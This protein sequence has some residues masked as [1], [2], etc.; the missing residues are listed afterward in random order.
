MIV[1]INQHLIRYK[2]YEV[3]FLSVIQNSYILLN[4]SDYILLSYI[5]LV[6]S[7]YGMAFDG[8]NSWNFG[9]G[10][11]ENVVTFSAHHLMIARKNF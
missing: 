8:A 7:G 4:L 1:F 5:T 11:A 3:I 6:F 10:F 2:T 9:N